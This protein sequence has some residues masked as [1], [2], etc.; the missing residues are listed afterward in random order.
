MDDRIL[1]DGLQDE[2]RQPDIQM[3]DLVESGKPVNGRIRI[4]FGLAE[5][6]GIWSDMEY[7]L[8]TEEHPAQGFTPDAMFPLIYAEKGLLMITLTARAPE[9]VS[10]IEGGSAVNVVSDSCKAELALPEGGTVSV[11]TAGKSA[12][13]S[14]PEEGINAISL[15]MK[16]L[17]GHEGYE[18]TDGNGGNNVNTCSNGKSI[19]AFYH[20]CIGM[21]TDGRNFVGAEPDEVS[22]HATVNP[23]VIK[24]ENGNIELKIDIR[25]PVSASYDEILNR[26]E[27]TAES[28]G[29][30]FKVDVHKDPVHLAFDNP[31]AQGLLSA[32]RDVTGD[33]SEPISIGGGTYARAMKNIVAFGPVLPGREMTEHEPDEYIYLEDLHLIR[34]IYRKALSS[35]S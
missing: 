12:H 30:T 24:L 11:C 18:G 6:T 3:R 25:Y 26:I 13:A 31:F 23:G 33:H 19:I 15:M 17:Y 34:E 2:E 9:Y 35:A 10:S 29:M 21:D 20:D 27:K 28:Y 14:M 32:Y 7:Y 8:E 4:I 5:E 1:Y 16:T 22:G